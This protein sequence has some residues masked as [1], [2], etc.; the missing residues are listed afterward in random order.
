MTAGIKKGGESGGPR[1]E[2]E[3]QLLRI[4][5]HFYYVH[6]ETKA[7]LWYEVTSTARG[8]VC[9]CPHATFKHAKCKHVSTVERVLFG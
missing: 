5:E 2:I 3:D 8:W 1:I 9:S 4:E 6:S 7:N